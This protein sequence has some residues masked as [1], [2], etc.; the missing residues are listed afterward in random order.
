MRSR[1]RLQR[2]ARGHPPARVSGAV[3]TH[4]RVIPRRPVAAVHPIELRRWAHA[5]GFRGHW[6]TKSCRWSTTFRRLREKRTEWQI[7]HRANQRDD[8]EATSPDDEIDLVPHFAY[9]GRGWPTAGQAHLAACRRR[10]AA[11][12]RQAARDALLDERRSRWPTETQSG[13]HRT[14]DDSSSSRVPG[15]SPPTTG[16]CRAT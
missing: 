15:A 14:D 3:E 13:A 5:L 9:E 1:G 16:R 6:L 2:N 12:A 8:G 11:A 10:E 7:A 4:G